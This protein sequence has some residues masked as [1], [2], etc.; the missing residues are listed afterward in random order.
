MIFDIER[1]A[2]A[3]RSASASW[4]DGAS[5]FCGGGATLKVMK[6]PAASREATVTP[7]SRTG[8]APKPV[9]ESPTI[10]TATSRFSRDSI[11]IPWIPRTNSRSESKVVASLMSTSQE[12]TNIL[13]PCKTLTKTHFERTP[14][15]MVPCFTLAKF[16]FS[17]LKK[18]RQI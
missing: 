16:R 10:V 11:V 13:V 12:N 1:A 5:F 15:A 3:A 6:W 4:S 14:D 8:R 7:R 18:T 17:N 2:D 9:L